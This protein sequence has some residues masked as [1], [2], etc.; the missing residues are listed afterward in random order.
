MVDLK[1]ASNHTTNPNLCEQACFLMH[2]CAYS[3]QVI[4]SLL[5]LV[6]KGLASISNR[7]KLN[8]VATLGFLFPMSLQGSQF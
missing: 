8:Y 1:L 2:M 6:S 7:S 5:T 3:Q 4:S